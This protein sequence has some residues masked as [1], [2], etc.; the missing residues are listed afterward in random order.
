[1]RLKRVSESPVGKS[2]DG[3][4]EALREIGFDEEDNKCAAAEIQR[5][6]KRPRRQNYIV[7]ERSSTVGVKMVSVL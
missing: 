4:L 3:V 7:F 5:L 1:M 2:I 6:E